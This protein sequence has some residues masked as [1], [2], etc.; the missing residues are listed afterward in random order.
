MTYTKV[1][2]K[3]SM[4]RAETRCPLPLQI[5]EVFSCYTVYSILQHERMIIH[6]MITYVISA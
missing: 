4:S 6:Y 3:N 2:S 1:N 5:N